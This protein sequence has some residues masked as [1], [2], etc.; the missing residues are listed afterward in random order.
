[1]N[2]VLLPMSPPRGGGEK[3]VVEQDRKMT[4]EG[5]IFMNFYMSTV[6]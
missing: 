6:F 4:L 5:D 1:M 3:G 2:K